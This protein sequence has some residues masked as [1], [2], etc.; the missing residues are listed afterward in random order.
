MSTAAAEQNTVQ[1]SRQGVGGISFGSGP[2]HASPL[3]RKPPLSSYELMRRSLDEARQELQGLDEKHAAR[4]RQ[5]A[6]MAGGI[7][8]QQAVD[9]LERDHRRWTKNPE[10]F[11]KSLGRTWMGATFLVT[12]WRSLAEAL[13]PG[14]P[15]LSLEIIFQA[16]MAAGSHWKVQH[17]NAQGWWLMARYLAQHDD[18]EKQ[19]ELWLKRSRDTD[20]ASHLK[21]LSFYRS[22]NPD[23]GIS[24]QQLLERAEVEA[25]YWSGESKRLEAEHYAFVK[26]HEQNAAGTGLGD[27]RMMADARIFMALRKAARDYVVKLEKEIATLKRERQKERDKKE[28]GLERQLMKLE[29]SLQPQGRSTQQTPVHFPEVNSLI[30]FMD[31]LDP[32]PDPCDEQEPEVVTAQVQPKQPMALK[33][34][35][36]RPPARQRK[37]DPQTHERLVE[38]NLPTSLVSRP[39]RL[40]KRT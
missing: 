23:A 1:G 35:K 33:A 3:I 37:P 6:G 36:P 40:F 29:K 17:A 5:E 39:K 11:Q 32:I 22:Q 16:M 19:A 18:P 13:K 14:G 12:V 7:L 34:A 10:F 8:Y 2:N 38:L 26:F 28:K 20:S 24:H 30:D 27:R 31:N 9:R 25:G 4:I 15:G 21:R